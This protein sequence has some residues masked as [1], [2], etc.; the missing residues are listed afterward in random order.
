MEN[1]KPMNLK[2]LVSQGY[3][4]PAWLP[5]KNG[6]LWNSEGVS[7]R[8]RIMAS[9]DRD[10]LSRDLKYVDLSKLDEISGVYVF[11]TAKDYGAA[12][13]RMWN[14][15]FDDLGKDNL[16][17]MFFTGNPDDADV[18]L[19]A[20][21][22]DPK[23]L[24]GGFGSGWKEKHAYLGRI[25]PANLLSVN[26]FVRDAA[27]G[28]LVGFNTDVP[29]LLLPLKEKLQYIGKPGLEGRTV[30]MFG[31]GGVGK[32]I[33]RGFV[34]GGVE[35][36]VIINRTADRAKEMA[37]AANALRLGVAEYGGEDKIEHYLTDPSVDVAINVSKKGAEPL[38]KYS[39]FAIA[40]TRSEG[41][42]AQNYVEALEVS[43]KIA[44]ANPQ[45]VIYDI[46]LPASGVP[47]TLEIAR[48]AGLVNLV[49]GKGMVTNQGIIAIENV[50]RLSGGILG[51]KFNRDYARG[52][53]EEALK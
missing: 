10:N 20:L 48:E 22:A 31:A 2:E 25:E 17:A 23:N 8:A 18:V 28:K 3:I 14:T 42:V 49:D 5:E 38:E 6:M 35:K 36:L 39:A 1:E 24:G 21:T 33:A 34:N 37:D 45:M 19:P 46:N 11:L 13:P 30:V 43:R 53:F 4:F 12:S 50:Q 40:D 9:E 52:I 32:E 44:E 26:S 41:G 16:R 27:D 15:L 51:E 7:E 47:R 29:G